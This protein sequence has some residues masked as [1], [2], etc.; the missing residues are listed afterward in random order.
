MCLRNLSDPKPCPLV[1]HR[2]A[3]RLSA[4]VVPLGKT[5]IATVDAPSYS[6]PSTMV[7]IGQLGKN[8]LFRIFDEVIFDLYRLT[9]LPGFGT[10]GF[11]CALREHSAATEGTDRGL[12]CRS[13]GE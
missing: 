1:K 3:S 11:I 2:T 8:A 7:R 4:I 10:A 9:L 12:S 6:H 5:V 13:R